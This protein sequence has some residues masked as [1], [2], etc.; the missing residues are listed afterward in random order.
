MSRNR[1]C[2]SVIRTALLVLALIGATDATALLITSAT[3][4]GNDVVA[5]PAAG[6]NELMFTARF[7]TLQSLQ[8]DV[9][10]ESSDDPFS[11]IALTE[12]ARD[13][14]PARHRCRFC[15]RSAVCGEYV[16]CHRRGGPVA[17]QYAWCAFV[18]HQPDPERTAG[19]GQCAGTGDVRPRTHR[20]HGI[21]RDTA[22]SQA[23]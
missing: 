4:N 11:P 8:F 17:H 22:L 9:L 19:G 21:V 7:H 23:R 10:I 18:H 14:I 16:R 20:V 1:T 5:A 2:K 12:F 6:P 15:I 3:L 13:G